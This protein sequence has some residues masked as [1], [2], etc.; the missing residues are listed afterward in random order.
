MVSY[1]VAKTGKPHTIV[2]DFILPATVDMT[3]TMLGEKAQKTIQTMPP[4]N[5]TVSRR[6]SDMAG[7]I[8]K[9]LLFS[10]QSS[11]FYALQ[12][13]SQQTWQAWHSSWYISVTFMGG[14]LRKTSSSA[15]HWKRG[16]QERT[17]IKYWTAL[18][19]QRDFGGQDVLVSVL[20][21]KSHERET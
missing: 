21:C 1:R 10:I 5:N 7:D 11:E 14:Q 13:I 4:S 2:E 20:M 9:Q 17:L 16:Q 15:N 8:L 19:H 12:L 6:I 3:G 18:W